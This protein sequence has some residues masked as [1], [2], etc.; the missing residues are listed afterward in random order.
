[1]EELP[2][3]CYTNKPTTTSI[4]T[5]AAMLTTSTAAG[6]ILHRAGTTAGVMDKSS[7]G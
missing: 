5:T 3:T 2:A 6:Y 7:E 4:S 1:M